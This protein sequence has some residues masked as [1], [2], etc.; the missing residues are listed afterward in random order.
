ML[1]ATHFFSALSFFLRD[2]PSIDHAENLWK[3]YGRR[4]VDCGTHEAWNL[5]Y[6]LILCHHYPSLRLDRSS[7]QHT[8][9][10]RPTTP[11]VRQ[12]SALAENWV[13]HTCVAGP[14]AG[15]I[16][17]RLSAQRSPRHCKDPPRG[18]QGSIN[19]LFIETLFHETK[20]E[21]HTGEW[22]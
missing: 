3:W 15:G 11:M 9:T 20:K 22:S 10:Q 13:A 14:G 12:A 19:K 5:Q 4:L 8:G 2:F 16:L 6:T 21:Q 17:C 1:K 7:S 18:Y